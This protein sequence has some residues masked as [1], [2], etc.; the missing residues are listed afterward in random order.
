MAGSFSGIGTHNIS[1]FIGGITNSGII[2]VAATG[3]GIV[4]GATSFFGNVSNSGTITGGQTGIYICDCVTFHGG[5]IVNTG[6]ISGSIYGIYAANA[7][8]PVTIDQQAGTISGTIALSPNADVVNVNGGTIL[9]DIVGQG[10]GTVNFALSAPGTYT[11]NNNFTN[12]SRVNVGNGT[13]LVVNGTSNSAITVNV[14]NG[15]TL[16]GTGS[17][18]SA[19]SINSG[20]ALEPG[21]P[22]TA[23]GVLTIG[24]TLSFVPGASYVDTIVGTG[25]VSLASVNGAAT[26]GGG[27]VVISPY[28]ALQTGTPYT[29]LTDTSGGLGIGGNTF[30]AAPISFEHLTGSL[31]Y[32]ADDV[33][34][35]FAAPAGCAT[36]LNTATVPCVLETGTLTGPVGN[37]SPGNVT[38]TGITAYNATITGNLIN[39]GTV[40]GGIAI[41]SSTINGQISDTG[42][43]SGGIFIDSASKIAA[44]G[45]EAAVQVTG[46]IFTGG[47]ANYGTITS[48]NG[49]VVGGKAT[50]T[51][52]SIR[53]FGGGISNAG[54][55]VAG[56]GNGI[57]VGGTALAGG[58]VTV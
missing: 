56:G 33:F 12:V 45:G 51:A 29:I 46:P 21:L 14:S 34:L 36:G 48:G 7:T 16:A 24:G 27:S 17:I 57:W 13:T 35:T 32:S 37:A 23:G 31:S 4:V 41:D 54:S 22:G 50:G 40:T 26:L 2:T 5:A 58:S 11:D 3:A 10:N 15:G 38:K 49:I 52:L 30:S 25:N 6:L 1:T 28:S 42:T 44:N 53:S 19:I 18:T 43:L 55:V 9:G 8:S 20:G 47:I 39:S